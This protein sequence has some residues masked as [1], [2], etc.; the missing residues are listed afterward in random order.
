MRKTIIRITTVALC[1]V[2]S[3]TS[4]TGVAADN[5]GTYTIHGVGVGSCGKFIGAANEGNFQKNWIEWNKYAAYTQGYITGINELLNGT[6]NILGSTD[7]EGLMGA[8]ENYCKKNPTENFY[9]ALSYSVGKLN[10]DRA[11]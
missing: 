3:T 8:V 11:K 9:N 5:E 10:T 2:V 4:V 1:A 7:L 6:R